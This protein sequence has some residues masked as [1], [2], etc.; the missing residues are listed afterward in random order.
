MLTIAIVVLF[1]A[2]VGKSI[3]RDSWDDG[4]LSG[5]LGA[6][7][8]AV[9]GVSVGIFFAVV[10]DAPTVR[11]MYKPLVAFNDGSSVQGHMFLGCGTIE[12]EDAYFYYESAGA[13]SFKRGRLV[14]NNVVIRETAPKGEGYLE[15]FEKEY[16]WWQ[17]WVAVD[18]NVTQYVFTVPK[19][20]VVRQFVADLKD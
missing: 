3:R 15:S 10:F 11:T 17:W 7:I 4:D 12:S 19:G 5:A 14:D 6:G 18:P 20:T 8:G 1:C 2:W 13:D 9:L 16:K